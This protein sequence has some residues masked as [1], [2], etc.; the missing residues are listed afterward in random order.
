MK[1]LL[2][3]FF[4][5]WKH[6]PLIQTGALVVLTGT[7]T[8]I[9]SIYLFFSNMERILV[10]WGSNIEMNIFLKDNLGT[11]E[12]EKIKK[13]L[14]D[15][16]YFKDVHFVT[17][18]DAASQFFSKM[19]RYIPEFAGEKEFLN[20]V[21]S[22]F[23]ASL[24]PGGNLSDFKKISNKVETV[25]GVEDVSY[26]QEWV[27]NFSIFVGSIKNIGWAISG[28]LILGSLFVIGFTVYAVIVRR[29]DEI[30]IY[31]L[32]GATSRMI[33]APYIFEGALISLMAGISALVMS[34]FI[35]TVQNEFFISKMIYLG[36][37]DLF[38]FFG[39]IEVLS[40]L[41]FSAFVGAFVSYLCIHKLNTGWT[42]TSNYSRGET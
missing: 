22:S 26:G 37:N 38:E 13:E 14:V 10:S 41:I 3:H 32:C 42:R 5:S 1:G 27:E 7:F 19:S 16:N 18:K 15:L 36:L 23:V 33:Q 6:H 24:L 39:V 34:Y 8:I 25:P 11:D 4:R 31:E 30:E 29:R 40:L 17:Q 21:P 28:I 12:V 9:F 2:T 35:L 20:I